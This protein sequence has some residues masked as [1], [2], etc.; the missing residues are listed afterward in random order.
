MNWNRSTHVEKLDKIWIL[1]DSKII[2]KD[3]TKIAIQINGKTRGVIEFNNKE[4]TEDD[5]IKKIKDVD[6]LYKYIEN[7]KITKTIYIKDKILNLIIK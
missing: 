1:A 3:I 2:N 4:I 7:E 5:I 6:S